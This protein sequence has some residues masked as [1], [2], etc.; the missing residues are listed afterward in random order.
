MSLAL[1]EVLI[2]DLCLELPLNVYF[3]FQI[4]AVFLSLVRARVAVVKS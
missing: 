1:L 4:F 2:L 3:K